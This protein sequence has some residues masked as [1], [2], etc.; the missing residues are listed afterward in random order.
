M[1]IASSNK[2]NA[3]LSTENLLDVEVS[4]VLWHTG[5]PTE[6]PLVTLLGGKLYKKGVST[7][8]DVGGKIARQ[9]SKEQSYK[10]IEKDP[11][12]R[13]ATV[14][15]AVADTT[16]TSVT[17]DSATNL[18]AGDT[19]KNVN[20]GEFMYIQ[21]I[22]TNTLTV[23]RN[24][25]SS[26]YTIGDD[27]TLRIVGFAH[28][29]GAAKAAKRSQLA[30]ARTRYLQIFKRTWGL[31]GTA[32]KVELV[33]DTGAWSEEQTQALA[34]HKKDI[35]FS[36]WWNP[37]SDSV[38]D[39]DSATVYLSR[40]IIEEIKASSDRYTDM[41]GSFDPDAF[42]GSVCED[43]FR[44]GPQAKDFFV[45][46]RMRS[47]IN[48]EARDKHRIISSGKNKLGVHVDE[49]DTGHGILRMMPCGAFNDFLSNSDQ[50]FGV[51]LDLG[52]VKYRFLPGRDTLLESGI[53]TPG[54]DAKEGQYI[55]EGGFSVLSLA[56]HHVIENA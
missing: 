20:T 34:N 48:K 21:S 27:D 32:Q 2:T 40:G 10:V 33:V 46:S 5:E 26:S 8:E 11:L 15:G 39:S 50:G 22:S 7:P 12:A 1:T 24:V 16:T 37:A 45:N 29:E 25:G 47:N 56:H 18:K 44:Y 49:I 31:T 53:Q 17:V 28:T 35:E 14:N 19:V 9:S 3:N 43:V 55:T 23:E 38:T 4:P 30:A 6:C 54:T 36:A 51:V 42:F 41:N 13:T 52:R